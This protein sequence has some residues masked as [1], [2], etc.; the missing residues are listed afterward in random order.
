MEDYPVSPLSIPGLLKQKIMSAL[1]TAQLQG[2]NW[3]D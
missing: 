3:V 1:V 2:T